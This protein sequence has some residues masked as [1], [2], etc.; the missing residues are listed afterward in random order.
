MVTQDDVVRASKGA[1]KTE[2]PVQTAPKVVRKYD[3]WGYVD[4]V[5]LKGIRKITAQHM[6]EAWKAP[7]VTLMDE[8]DVT[9]L[10][11]V[12]DKEKVKAEKKGVK[13]TY[14]AYIVKATVEALKKHPLLNA[15]L[16]DEDIIVKKYLNI[17][18]AVDAGDGLVVP[19]VKGADKKDI[20]AIAT[21]IEKYAGLAKT[22]KLDLMDMQGG[23]FTISNVGVIAG[24]FFTPVLNSPEVAILGIGRMAEKAVVRDGKIVVRKMLP[25]VVTFDHRVVDGAEAARF[26]ADLIGLLQNPGAL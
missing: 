26:M 14:L 5:P 17:G 7:Q 13:L 3:M 20:Y 15:S 22:K 9:E 12:R 1:V 18:I 11:A 2:A 23:S 6:N 24:T 8:A 4:H 21:E 16:E 25:L 19:V 10:A